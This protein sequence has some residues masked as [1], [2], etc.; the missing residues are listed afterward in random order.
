MYS[1]NACIALLAGISGLCY[2]LAVVK[3]ISELGYPIIRIIDFG[4]HGYRL[5][6]KAFGAVIR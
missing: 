5:V 3:A 6:D 2:T 1:F 4:D